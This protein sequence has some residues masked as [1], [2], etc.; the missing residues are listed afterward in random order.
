MVFNGSHHAG[1][2]AAGA[3]SNALLRELKNPAREAS[4]TCKSATRA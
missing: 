3:G 2:V 1:D 4:A